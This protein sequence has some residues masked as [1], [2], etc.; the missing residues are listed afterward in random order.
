MN[1]VINGKRYDTDKAKEIGSWESTWDFRSVNYMGET[2]YRKR[3]GEF[4]LHC[5]R[6]MRSETAYRYC[7]SKMVSDGG[8]HIILL[9]Y[10]QAQ[11]W[12]EENMTGDEYEAVFG[13][14]SEDAGNVPVT[15][16]LPA[17]TRMRL[18][19]RA[20]KTG[21][22]QSA[23]VS[24]LIEDSRTEPRVKRFTAEEVKA[25]EVKRGCE[26]YE[27]GT[28]EC[29][30]VIAI[31]VYCE[32]VADI[33]RAQSSNIFKTKEEAVA[34]ATK[35]NEANLWEQSSMCA[36]DVYIVKARSIN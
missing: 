14:V 31:H 29:Y 32:D 2:L 27:H 15:L 11:E 4:F 6:G 33:D 17:A 1:K 20:T 5:E 7:D 23:I 36:Q 13:E 10:E 22:S 24:E 30:E 21:K 12:A 28:G 34:F 18:E 9:S 3:T 25:L 35:K 26:V 16:S 19:S 8:E